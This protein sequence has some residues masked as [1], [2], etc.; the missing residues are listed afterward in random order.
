[1]NGLPEGWRE[2]ALGEIVIIDSGK[3]PGDKSDKKTDIFNVPLV[4]ASSTMGYVKDALYKEP[5][6]I[7]GRVGTHG[8]VQRIYCPSFPSDNTL[9]LHS[10]YFE[11]VYQIL[12]TIDYTSLNV[13][14]TQPLITQTAIKKYQVTIPSDDIL[15]KYEISITKLFRKVLANN[16]N[17]VS[18]EEIR[19][20]LLPK[21]MTGEVAV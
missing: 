14:T 18:L 5:I 7:I 4:G 13:G 1:V 15:K 6:L 9:I 19:D 20:S 3:R 11:Y 16:Q 8:I 17:N 12:K 2:G 21:L 10:K